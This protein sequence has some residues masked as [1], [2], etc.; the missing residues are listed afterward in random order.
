MNL[1]ESKKDGLAEIYS[2]LVDLVGIKNTEIIYENLKG[3]QVVFP[4]RLYR[5][6]FVEE[7]VKERYDGKNLKSLASEYGYTERYLR[8]FLK[9]QK[10][11]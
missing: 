5:A 7:E 10:R 9:K 1:D 6:D 4:M 11:K 3:Q 2:Q 8:Q